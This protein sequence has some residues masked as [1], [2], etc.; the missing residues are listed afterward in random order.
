MAI[1][2]TNTYDSFQLYW[3]GSISRCIVP[4]AAQ[5]GWNYHI[6][7]YSS[8]VE[9]SKTNGFAHK[10]CVS[11]EV[12]VTSSY[13]TLHVST[14]D[15]CFIGF[16][17][18][19]LITCWSCPTNVRALHQYLGDQFHFFPQTRLLNRK[20]QMDPPQLLVTHLSFKKTSI[21][22]LKGG[23]ETLAGSFNPVEIHLSKW[24]SSQVGVKIK[25]IWNHHPVTLK[26]GK[27]TI[28]TD[29]LPK[30]LLGYPSK[31]HKP[32]TAQKKFDAGNPTI[33]QCR[34]EKRHVHPVFYS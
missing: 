21:F 3:F 22:T 5:F 27:E 29:T 32:P 33:R 26:R 2:L 12:I 25:N 6:P 18:P 31:N 30:V 10:Y 34:R 13:F 15:R 24:E 19:M 17:S 14:V 20:C 28:L 8:N 11:C 16:H 9:R 23:K 4:N 1:T 7:S